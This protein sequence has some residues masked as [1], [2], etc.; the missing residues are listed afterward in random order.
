VTLNF[1]KQNTWRVDR[2]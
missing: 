1:N 2:C